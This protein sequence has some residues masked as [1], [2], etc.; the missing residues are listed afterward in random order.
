MTNE[1]LLQLK[2]LKSEIRILKEQIENINFNIV[3][4]SVKAS[5]RF[6]PYTEHNVL[7][8]GIDYDGYNNKLNRLQRKLNRRV[9][10][11][12]DLVEDMN[13]YISNID[14]SLVRQVLTLRYINNL[15]WN[16]VAC[17]IGGNNTADSVRKVAERYLK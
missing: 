9:E 5:S 1:E 3:T 17:H 11:L 16:Q 2:Y 13:D 7:I 4:D 10:D 12:L 8:T 15:S 14:D 6:F